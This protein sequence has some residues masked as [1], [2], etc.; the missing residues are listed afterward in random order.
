MNKRYFYSLLILVIIIAG[1][2]SVILARGGSGGENR[3]LREG[4]R[5]QEGQPWIGAQIANLT[6]EM[7][8]KLELSQ[9]SGVVVLQVLPDGPADQAG[10]KK[11]DIITH[12]EGTAIE[13]ASQVVDTITGYQIGDTVALTV[14]RTEEGSTSTIDIDVTLAEFERPERSNRGQKP[15]QHGQ[16]SPQ[17]KGHKL[18]GLDLEGIEREEMFEHFL[19][20]DSR[21]TDKDG[22]PVNIEIIPGTVSAVTDNSLELTTNDGGNTISVTVTD[23]TIIRKGPKT[24]E[25]SDFQDGDKVIVVKSN[26]EVA[27]ITSAGPGAMVSG[28]EQMG[29]GMHGGGSQQG[30]GL[31]QLNDRIN[32]LRER[33]GELPGFGEGQGGGLNEQPSTQAF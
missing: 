11:A 13:T 1:S 22:N 20:S 15:G 21:F 2:T 14:I 19:G 12:I 17:M 10:I 31:P 27:A 26:G 9:E 29:T 6:A 18:P 7:A 32:E 30:R 28:M 3:Q 16:R 5:V 33:F 23:E 8:E 4:Q 24:T 25:L